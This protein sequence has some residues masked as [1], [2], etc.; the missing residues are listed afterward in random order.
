MAT[1]PASAPPKAGTCELGPLRV[2]GCGGAERTV[3]DAA[4]CKLEAGA[5]LPKAR[6]NEVCAGFD[7]RSCSVNQGGDRVFCH[8]ARPCLGRPTSLG[9]VAEA[10]LQEGDAVADHLA[11]ARDAEAE[12]VTAFVELANDLE[13]F[14]APKSLREACLRS[15]NDEAR[16][17]ERMAELLARRGGARPARA[18]SAAPGFASLFDLA[19]HNE[20]EGVVG[21]TWGALV[22]LHQAERAEGSA[23][24]EAMRAVADDETEHA[25]LSW[26][27]AAWARAL[28]SERERA[29]LDEARHDALRALR[30]SLGYRPASLEAEAELGWPSRAASAAMLDALAPAL[31]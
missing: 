17:A 10:T 24:R 20:R 27:I 5:D 23:T 6:C 9:P 25:A 31:A 16:H 1:A 7:T 28:V 18:G 30:A 15:A 26:R 3:S 19:L 29:L 12:S 11:L 4:A 13:R 21:E 8:A 2:T 14:G 22:A